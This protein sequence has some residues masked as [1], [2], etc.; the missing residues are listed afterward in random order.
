MAKKERLVGP[1]GCSGYPPGTIF[2]W[3]Y[4]EDNPGFL[5]P[6]LTT[7]ED[8]TNTLELVK[9]L[10]WLHRDRPVDCQLCTQNC[11]QEQEETTEWQQQSMAGY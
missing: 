9:R 5:K 11:G 10:G 1:S 4:R 6:I 8:Y 3:I 7:P 2:L